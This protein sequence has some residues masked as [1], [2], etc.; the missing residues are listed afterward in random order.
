MIRKSPSATWLRTTNS[1][2]TSAARKSVVAPGMTKSASADDRKSLS[3]TKKSTTTT[4]ATMTT[5]QSKVPVTIA[6]ANGSPN[7]PLPKSPSKENIDPERTGNTDSN[8][9][10]TIKSKSRV[11]A[12]MKED[13]R[14]VQSPSSDSGSTATRA[15]VRRKGSNDTIIPSKKKKV[16]SSTAGKA[17]TGSSSTPSEEGTP[18]TAP[19]VQ[20]KGATLDIGIPCLIFSKR[21]R[22]RAFARYI[23]EVEGETGPW[24]GVEVPVTGDGWDDQQ[25]S[26]GRAWH[27]GSWGGVKYFDVG[28]YTS[29][30]GDDER[31]TRRRRND[32][33]SSFSSQRSHHHHHHNNNN[34][35]SYHYK[36][37][38][39]EGDTLSIERK[40]RM[41]SGSPS[42]SDVSTTEYRGLF[43]RPQQVLY[44]LDAV[45]DL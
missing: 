42:V 33:S 21:K 15:T 18:V 40:K 14:N 24:V 44:V 31:L 12:T 11:E 41:R 3:G 38:K 26:D 43:V 6:N 45:G 5:P 28:S 1:T 20:P 35:G 7:K 9:N 36:G 4:S 10:K 13:K 19:V 23:G 30:W 32:L 25:Q 17:K 39:R 16:V 2:A 34:Y 8:N 27:D 37:T 22:F 29:E